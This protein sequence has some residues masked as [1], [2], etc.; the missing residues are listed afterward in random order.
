[1]PVYTNRLALPSPTA[2]ES[3][4]GPAQILALTNV[5]DPII[6]TDAQGAIADRPV[7]TAAVPGIRG[8][9]YFATDE[10]VLYRDHGTG[11]TTVSTGAPVLIALPASPVSGQ[12]ISYLA[13]ATNGVVWRLKYRSASASVYKW[14]FIGGPPLFAEVTAN[15][16]TSSTTYVA[17]ATAGPVVTL[18]LAGDYD[19]AVGAQIISGAAAGAVASMSY[20]IGATAAVQADA[21]ELSSTF[22][23]GDRIQGNVMRERR[24]TG[25][26]AVAL[27]AKYRTSAANGT[28]NSRWMRVTPVRVG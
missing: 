21:A 19:V 10:N 22:T 15:E 8:R 14:E 27:T 17:L 11:W 6:A 12:E 7:S 24:K 20:D 28:F 18:P 1:M 3:P 13:D 25:L 9:Y 23:G 5:L 2:S 16:A 26:A 4:D